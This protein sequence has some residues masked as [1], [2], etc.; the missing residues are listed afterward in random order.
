MYITVHV[1]FKNMHYTKE[2]R[3]EIWLSPMT[4]ALIP[5]EISKGGTRQHNTVT[6]KF[7]YT[8]I[9]DQTDLWQSDEVTTVIQ[10]VWF[11]GFPGP[12]FPLI[13]TVV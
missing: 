4:K 5:T 1:S 8:A 13:A 6:K 11:T 10:L 9:A 2:K 12:T 3:E 7:D